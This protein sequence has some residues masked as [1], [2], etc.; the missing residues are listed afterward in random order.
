MNNKKTWLIAL[1]VCLL[2]VTVAPLA[3]SAP[4]GLERIAE[5]KGFAEMARPSPFSVAADYLFPGIENKAVAT[6]L[7]G[8]LGTIMVF[9][10]V[11]GCAILICRIKNS[12]VSL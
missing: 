2:L 5:E 1:A 8:W 11:Y 6:L 4:D 9:F 7:A 3:S 12:P 10:L